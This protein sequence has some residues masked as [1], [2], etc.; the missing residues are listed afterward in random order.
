MALAAV[1]G[2]RSL[3]SEGAGNG[4]LPAGTI[5]KIGTQVL[6]NASGALFHSGGTVDGA[7]IGGVNPAAGTFSSLSVPSG[8]LMIGANTLA[9]DIFFYMNTVAGKARQFIVQT[10]G[11]ARWVFGPDATSETGSNAGTDFVIASFNDAGAFIN[12]PLVVSRS[13]GI[14]TILTLA[15]TNGTFTNFVSTGN[16]RASVATGLTA[17]GTTQATALVLTKDVSVIT[18]A[19]SGAGYVL[20]NAGAGALY[21]IIN[22]GAN[23]ANAFPSSGGIIDA[24]ASNAATTHA[25]LTVKRFRQV[26][27]TQYYTVP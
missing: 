24:L 13:S 18:V 21:E 27:A 5:I 15:A 26:S 17:T 19:A 11:V 8:Q 25:A 2:S 22:R 6:V 23:T 10:A 12:R 3:A 9:A 1:P 14:V 16:I 7:I 4:F 20:P